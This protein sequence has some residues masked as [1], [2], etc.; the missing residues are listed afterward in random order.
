[1]KIYFLI[2]FSLI[3]TPPTH[4]QNSIEI[5]GKHPI[6]IFSSKEY[7]AGNSVFSF[8]Q[9]RNEM[10]Y[11]GNSQGLSIYNG[12]S[13]ELIQLPNKSHVLW[14]SLDEKDNIYI[15][16]QDEFGYLKEEYG[17]YHYQTLTDLLPDSIQGYGSLWEVESTSYGTYFRTTKY[18]FWHH[19]NELTVLPKDEYPG[20]TYDVIFSVRDTLYCR[21][22]N[23][24]LVK[25]VGKDIQLVPDG[26]FF[27]KIKTNAI[28][29]FD[30]KILVVTRAQG[31]YISDESGVS[32]FKNEVQE[33]LKKFK[34]YHAT[35]HND[36]IAIA[37]LTKGVFILNKKGEL[38]DHI[39]EE[40]YGINEA[41]NY[42][43]FDTQDAL[44][45]ASENGAARIDF[46]EYF[47]VFNSIQGQDIVINDF[48]KINNIF[49]FATSLGT[50]YSET[51]DFESAKK[52]AEINNP[53]YNLFQVEDEVMVEANNGIYKISD[54]FVAVKQK[55]N[56]AEY[57]LRGSAYLTK[58]KS[59][60]LIGNQEGLT[61][62][63][64]TNKGEFFPIKKLDIG[65]NIQSV[66]VFEPNKIWACPTHN[67]IKY[68]DI[69]TDSIRHFPEFGNSKVV[70]VNNTPIF[71]TSKGT[72]EYVDSSFK[73]SAF[74]HQYVDDAQ[75]EVTSI[76]TDTQGNVL[77]LYADDDS[78]SH[79]MWLE[80]DGD[81]QYTAYTLPDIGLTMND[82]TDVYLE[83]GGIVWLAGN[84][85]IF[86]IDIKKSRT[87]NTLLKTRLVDIY[88][89][90]KKII[91]DGSECR[92]PFSKN[93]IRFNYAAIYY[94]S[95]GNNQ[96]QYKLE[97]SSN[98][99]SEWTEDFQKEYS[100]LE[101]GNYAFHVRSKNP[102]D[103]ISEVTTYSFTILPPWYRSPWAFG[104]YFLTVIISI[105]IATKVRSARLKKEN[106]LL[107]EMVQERTR[108]VAF[109]NK[110]L[111]Q[112][113]QLKSKFFANISHELRTPLTLIHGNLEALQQGSKSSMVKQRVENSKR[114]ANQLSEMIE[115]LLDLSKLEL[116]QSNVL[117]KPTQVNRHLNRMV[118]S[119]QSF[120]ESKN[121]FLH[122]EDGWKNP[123]HANMDIRQFEKV[124]NNLLYNAFKFTSQNGS[125]SVKTYAT[126]HFIYLEII[127]TGEGIE[128]DELPYIFDRFYQAKNQVSGET[129]S[130]LGLAITKEIV[131]L[132]EGTIEV[133][134][135]LN[136]GTS[137]I[138][139]LPR[140]L[141]AP[142]E[143]YE[144]EN[145][146]LENFLEK[147]ILKGAVD[148]SHILVVEDNEEMQE[149]LYEILQPHFNVS[150][151]NH[152]QEALRWLKTNN[153]ELIISDV[154]M[155]VMSGF[156][157]LEQLKGSPSYQHIPVIMLTA[158][159][160]KEDRMEGLRFGVDDYITKPFERDE[161]LVR[162]INLIM[163]L[164]NRISLSQ[165]PAKKTSNKASVTITK[166]DEVMVK[167]AEIYIESRMSNSSLSVREVASS[168]A[169]SERQFYRKIGQITGMTPANF[170]LEIKL[171]Y[172]HQKLVNGEISK[173]DQISSAVGISSPSYFSKLFYERFG[174]RPSQYLK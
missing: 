10:L 45:I 168:V 26:E 164:K 166:E 146:S 68:Y 38:T 124:I 23:L 52:I 161:L 98:E 135:K 76:E 162:T 59:Q 40:Q 138:I 160:S 43:Y 136:V 44:W 34:V 61:L 64:Y 165:E 69:D 13:W 11:M 158:R 84:S 96:Y 4:A 41:T 114:N 170:M 39:T 155:P 108:E 54:D 103:V 9:D 93:N 14:L 87:K 134:S 25:V 173:L 133:K 70:M 102:N 119:F 106:K 113:D 104:G 127:D 20:S 47:R 115:D 46:D 112:L 32:E 169:M 88:A 27:S 49:Y 156:E 121:I 125:V 86:K 163:N 36:M 91:N 22:R 94:N 62:A 147:T 3:L 153:P 42:V 154:M 122:Y 174:K 16:G 28:L 81:E 15:A 107:E 130:G 131:E 72:F 50:F 37:S 79:G 110:K 95:Y 129:G 142:E 71:V 6:R 137:F 63:K 67:G 157:L 78:N 65:N 5:E 101:E 30:D 126:D 90:G 60:Y 92:I 145:P 167:T 7:K 75:Y 152:G 171:H 100:Y 2:L 8:V 117:L 159:S 58:K 109:K 18:L 118:Q 48:K 123:V 132:H 116:G 74:I 51:A 12:A 31:I 21:K 148:K 1:M 82:Y 172:A 85:G 83:D 144:S 66:L 17:D 128:N 97:G 151:V 77:L 89:N 139:S 29:A 143:E 35:V 111:Q 99:W 33:E 24:G 140:I 80:Q 55:N 19:E 57:F 73:K 149:Y 141:D 120:A 56:G 105:V 150:Q 53:C